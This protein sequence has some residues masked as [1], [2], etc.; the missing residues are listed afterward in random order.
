MG[1]YEYQALDTKGRTRKGV[2]TGDTPRQVRQLLRDMELIPLELVSISNTT[3]HDSPLRISNKKVSSSELA[4]ITRQFATLLGAGLTIEEALDGL[5]QQTDRHRAHTI[6]N[7][8]RAMIMEGQSLSDAISNFPAT[9]PSIYRA[10]V[11]AGEESGKLDIVMDRLA[12]YTENVDAVRRRISIALIYPVILTI[13]A[14]LIVSALLTYVVPK[15]VKVFEESGQTLPLLTRG[16]INVSEFLQTWGIWILLIILLSFIVFKKF[17][18]R[19]GPRSALHSFYLRVPVLRNITRNINTAA[20]ARTL[21][22]MVGSGVP[23]LKSMQASSQVLQ[24]DAMKSAMVAAKTEVGEG[25]PLSKALKHSGL[26]PPLLAQMVAS[27][28]SSG[29]LDKMLEKTAEVQENELE[30]RTSMLV[31]LFEPAMILT[32]GVVVLV[33]V[34]AILLPIFDLN[35][36]IYDR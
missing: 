29:Q 36:L 12:D 9:F 4:V 17:F 32:M 3:T 2:I 1:A 20:M 15:V 31:G 11:A 22:I 16:L 13:I 35:E 23:L 24:N 21:S 18:N 10:T 33:I 34:L 27:G 19:P 30:A 7:G 8:I 26:F 6:L 14:I 25:V 5:I 28:E